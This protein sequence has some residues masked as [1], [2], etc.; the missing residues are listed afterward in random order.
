MKKALVSAPVLAYAD[1]QRPFVLEIDASHAGQGA[2][3]SQEHG[4]KLR[5]I[6]CASRA[7]KPTERNMQN[8]GSMKL[9]FL[10]LKWTVSEK[11]R[12]YLLGSSCTVFMDNNPLKHIY[13]AKLG[14]V[15]QRWAAQLTPF[16][17]ILNYHP[18]A[19]NGNADALSRQY[20]EASTAETSEEETEWEVGALCSQS[21]ISALA[22]CSKENL[23]TLQEQDPV[24]GLLLACWRKARPPDSKGREK[25]GQGT[26][27][28]AHQWGCLREDLYLPFC[29]FCKRCLQMSVG[30]PDFTR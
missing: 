15:E 28:L 17:L 9:E 27:E 22:G 18:G 14:A 4:E 12:R 8:Y 7:L 21:D 20:S 3:L 13:T 11:F 25:F 26:K 24:I 10:A 19:R 6:A 5:P 29:C 16:S 1:F 30:L 2:G 23:A